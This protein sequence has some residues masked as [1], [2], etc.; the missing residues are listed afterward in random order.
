MHTFIYIAPT[1]S[2]TLIL[3]SSGS[4]HQNF[5]KT[6]SNKRGHNNWS[7]F[8]METDFY[9]NTGTESCGIKSADTSLG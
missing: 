9:Y 6:Y 2:S 1:C 5:F 7:T 4:W 8:I 3:P